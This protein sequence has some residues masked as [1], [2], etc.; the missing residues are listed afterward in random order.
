[1]KEIRI[2]NHLIG[3]GHPCFFIAEAGAN[4]E[5]KFE[6]ALRLIDAAKKSQAD[7]IK[8]QHYSAGKLVSREAKRYWAV[9]GDRPG[10][11][12]DPHEYHDDQASTFTKIDGIPRDKDAQLVNYAKENT[13]EMFSTPF[14]F[15]SADHL[16]RLGVPA[17][18]IASGDITYHQFLEHVARKGKP[19]IL[20]TG[21]STFEEIRDAVRVV[22]ATG[23]DQ[24]VLLHCTL[25]YPTPLENAN[26]LMMK[27]LQ[28]EFPNVL[29]GLSDHTP[30]FEA[31]RAAALLGAVMIEKHF[32][33]TP[34]AAAGEN[35][36]GESPD[37][38]IGIGA[39]EFSA[40]VTAVRNDEKQGLSVRLGVD[41][42]RAIEM[43]RNGTCPQ[44]LGKEVAKKVDSV[45]EL[46]ARAQAR[47]SVVTEIALTKGTVI[48]EEMLK[49]GKLSIKRPGTGIQPYEISNLVG[50][51]VNQDIS[52]D[53]ILQ[54]HHFEI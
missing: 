23:N 36:V 3:A 26:L 35:K 8:F 41:F 24:L 28:E 52:P 29:V 27:N 12:F 6:E 46:K 38:D 43:V 7:A 51:A 48:T 16:E 19:I 54:W 15:E 14:D 40:M 50:K 53:S 44:V 10:F 17:Y 4:H 25:A 1:M 31:D 37:H 11:Q 39:E 47:R 30:G 22:L 42:E 33:H 20:S 2:G 13:I 34:G 49:D 18:K 32:T 45:V 5:G 9:R 21:A